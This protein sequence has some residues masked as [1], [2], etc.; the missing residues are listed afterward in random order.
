M[1]MNKLLVSFLLG[2][3]FIA[4]CKEK[5]PEEEPTALATDDEYV[6]VLIGDA[7]SKKISF[8]NMKTL[9]I[10]E[11]EANYSPSA[12]YKSTSGQFAFVNNHT[13]NSLQ[14]FNSGLESHGDH[15]DIEKPKIMPYAVTSSTPIHFAQTNGLNIF[16]N[17]GDGSVTLLK[18]SELE[19][20]TYSPVNV[21]L[22]TPHHGAAVNFKNGSIA[23]TELDDTVTDRIASI[24]QKIIIFDQNGKKLFEPSIRV[25][26]IHGSSN[27]KNGQS[28]VFGSTEGVLIVNS[29]GTTQLIAHSKEL[30]DAKKW[31]ASVEAHGESSIFYGMASGVGIF[32]IDPVKKVMTKVFA[33]ADILTYLYSKNGTELIV[34]T[35]D[36]TI[37]II[38]VELGTEIRSGSNLFPTAINSTEHGTFL[39]SIADSDKYIYVTS[40]DTGELIYIN[41]NNLSIA[42]KLKIAGK[43]TKI[44]VF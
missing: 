13:E 11:F 20:S 19:K 2:V 29:D 9:E 35:K 26:G 10:E 41:K 30:T 4:S 31:I 17:D 33:H 14:V 24:P 6:R 21:Q 39:P 15:F 18:E 7:D 16:F 42:G 25:K 22:V 12:I 43:P 1:K 44:T 8:V 34:A 37:K 27:Y 40:P 28:A 32:K 5:D 3:L 38:D 23:V 36:G